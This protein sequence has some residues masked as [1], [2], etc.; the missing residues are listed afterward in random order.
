MGEQNQLNMKQTTF[1]FLLFQIII[2]TCAK[3]LQKRQITVDSQLARQLTFSLSKGLNQFNH[4]L[5]PKLAALNDGNIVI[6]PFSLHTALSMTLIGTPTK[7][8]T[9]KQL[10]RALFGEDQFD[11]EAAKT[12]LVNYLKVIN[13][14]E[15]AGNDL[16]IKADYI[17]VL[18]QLFKSGLERVNFANSIETANK[19]NNYVYNVT[20]GLIDKIVQP[21]NFDAD[22]RML[23]INAIYFK[24]NWLTKFNERDTKP[25][26]FQVTNDIQV[27][28]DHGMNMRE[29]L[30]HADMADS[31]FNAQ[32]LELPYENENF[33]MLLIL[34][35]E[36]INIGELN[37]Q[38]L[39]YDILNTKLVQRKIQLRL[40]RFKMEFEAKMRPFLEEVGIS[41]LFE[42]SKADLSDIADEPLYV[43]DVTHK[44]VIEVNEE[45]SE[46]AG[47]SAVQI[48]TRTSVIQRFRPMIFD[49][50]FYFIIQNKLHN[51]NLFMGRIV[52]PSGVNGLGNPSEDIVPLSSVV[53]Q[54]EQAQNP[55]CDELGYQTQGDSN[56]GVI[57]PCTGESTLPL[58]GQEGFDSE[59]KQ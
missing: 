48:N 56:G 8:D 1:I 27:D 18:T 41:D 24:A 15:N 3:N 11:N 47:V 10:S 33:R 4:D 16:N 43:S 38:K 29:D 34:P 46:A 32:V 13:F 51:L 17:N 45:G 52:D 49:K 40:P 22:T 7:S 31:G 20:D 55:N 39:N 50:P 6:S 9:H 30:F 5:F 25:M 23:L 36:G 58:R 37:L 26:K 28:Y 59:N 42:K 21:S 53:R 44:S 2:L 54:S 57:L 14:Y 35:D 12:R 19:I